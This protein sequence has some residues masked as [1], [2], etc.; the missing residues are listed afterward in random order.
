MQDHIEFDVHKSLAANSSYSTLGEGKWLHSRQWS[1]SGLGTGLLD[2]PEDS[3]EA[4][5]AHFRQGPLASMAR[6]IH[7]HLALLIHTRKIGMILLQ[8]QMTMAFL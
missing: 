1:A 7:N 6:A 4:N 5:T 8:F 2:T 3:R